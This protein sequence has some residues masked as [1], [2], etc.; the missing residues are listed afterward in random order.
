[1]MFACAKQFQTVNAD[2]SKVVKDNDGKWHHAWIVLAWF[3]PLC[4]IIYV[5]SLNDNWKRGI[6]LDS[7]KSHANLEF[8]QKFF[9]ESSLDLKL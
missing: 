6:V 4:F 1:M 5:K 2:T 3:N 9:S 7:R 8:V